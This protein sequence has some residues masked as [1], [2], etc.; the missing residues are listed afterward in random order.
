ML[1]EPVFVLIGKNNWMAILQAQGDGIA[2][3]LSIHQSYFSSV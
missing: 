1:S 2:G 3:P